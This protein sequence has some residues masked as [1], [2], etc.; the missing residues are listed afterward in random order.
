M[1]RSQTVQWP[2]GSGFVDW[3]SC[4][5]ALGHDI[6]HV[7]WLRYVVFFSC[8]C[9]GL[10][11]GFDCT[12]IFPVLLFRDL[13]FNAGQLLYDCPS[14]AVGRFDAVCHCL[15]GLEHLQEPMAWEEGWWGKG[16]GDLCILSVCHWMC[17]LIMTGRI[18]L[19]YIWV[20]LVWFL[21]LLCSSACQPDQL[22]HLP[23]SLLNFPGLAVLFKLLHLC[24][25]LW[26][27]LVVL[28]WAK[29]PIDSIGKTGSNFTFVTLDWSVNEVFRK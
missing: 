28:K 22:C 13:Y 21:R 18:D 12:C 6:N 26:I 14:E 4:A 8:M 23:D 9:S 19:C 25:A 27:G 2:S 1:G 17:V 7:G 11:F 29:F 20:V 16:C 10:T 3:G 15:W 24:K 5:A